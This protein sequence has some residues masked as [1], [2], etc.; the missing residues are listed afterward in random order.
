MKENIRLRTTDK[1]YIRYKSMDDVLIQVPTFG[2]ICVIIDFGRSHINS[3]S[4][5][6]NRFFFN[7]EF[8]K[9]GQCEGL[10]KE[11]LNVDISRLILSLYEYFHIVED[12]DQCELINFM[13]GCCETVDKI[14]LLNVLSESNFNHNISIFEEIPRNKLNI[15]P[16]Q[17]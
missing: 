4:N 2:N 10:K 13:K 15:D 3:T 5:G 12:D 11:N 7:S 6:I 9:D 14:N 17:K 1:K 8:T 16:F